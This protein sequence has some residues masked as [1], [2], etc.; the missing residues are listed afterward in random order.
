MYIKLNLDIDMN[1]DE[2]IDYATADVKFY[3]NQLELIEERGYAF[4]L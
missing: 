3:E 4:I 2:V 1:I